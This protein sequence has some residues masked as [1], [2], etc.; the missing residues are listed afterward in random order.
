[1]LNYLCR[2]YLDLLSPTFRY[3][4]ANTTRVAEVS[5]FGHACVSK[6]DTTASWPDFSQY[7]SAALVAVTCGLIR[8]SSEQ[9]LILCRPSPRFLTRSPEHA[10]S[11]ISA[12]IVTYFIAENPRAG[13]RILP[14]L[15]DCLRPGF[16]S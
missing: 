2:P 10:A 13:Q 3:L 12:S 1:M 6:V 14:M 15:R 11:I 5:D 8:A 16:R 7:L 9:A 4:Q